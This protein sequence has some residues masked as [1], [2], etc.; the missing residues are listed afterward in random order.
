M[1]EN[2]QTSD[3]GL[4]SIIHKEYKNTKI[5]RGWWLHDTMNILKTTVYF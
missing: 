4:A 1:D 5:E 3:K 2:V